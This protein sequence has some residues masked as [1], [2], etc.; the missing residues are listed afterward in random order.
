LAF[1]GGTLTVTPAAL[2][3]TADGK[4]KVYGAAVPALTGSVQGLVNGDNITATFTTGATAASNVGSYAI[5][6]ALQDPAGKL[7]NYAVTFN[8]ATL[9]VTPAA[10]TVTADNQTKV[11]GAALPPP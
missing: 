3:V 6:A 8:N 1:A 9:T 5:T 10:L 11:Y 7:G 2:V 4:T